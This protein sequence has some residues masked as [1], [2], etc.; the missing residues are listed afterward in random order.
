MAD[1]ATYLPPWV[2][3][4]VHYNALASG[5]EW[6]DGRSSYSAPVTRRIEAFLNAS[7]NAL[8]DAGRF[9]I[10]AGVPSSR[11]ER[12]MVFAN[13][14]MHPMARLNSLARA[15]MYVPDVRS[16]RRPELSEK[17][18]ATLLPP[19]ARILARNLAGDPESLPYLDWTR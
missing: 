5:P 13:A 18:L 17:D 12:G 19:K 1:R 3:Q 6:D 7:P 2:D 15:F 16:G 14:L 8:A 11:V 10:A 9:A 4:D